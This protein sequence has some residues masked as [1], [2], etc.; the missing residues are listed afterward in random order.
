MIPIFTISSAVMPGRP[1]WPASCSWSPSPFFNPFPLPALLQEHSDIAATVQQIKNNRVFIA[2]CFLY[3]FNNFKWGEVA[4]FVRFHGVGFGPSW[5]T[6]GCHTD[7]PVP[8]RCYEV[9]T[10]LLVFIP[11]L[12]KMP[13][14]DVKYT[15]ICYVCTHLCAICFDSLG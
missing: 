7:V 15:Q 5:F 10:I 2:H 9:V 1:G 4:N 8:R 3:C 14:K 12:F 6:Q 11:K 13:P